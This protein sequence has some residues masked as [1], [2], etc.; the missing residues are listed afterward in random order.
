MPRKQKT[1][2]GHDAQKVE[3]V[4]GQRYGE[5]VEQQQMQTAMPAPKAAADVAPQV[6]GNETVIAAPQKQGPTPEMLQQF[7]AS[8]NPQLLSGT[9]IPDEPITAG[10]PSGPGPGP[11][12][13]S[14]GVNTTPIARTLRRLS[15]TTGNPKWAR[16]ADKANL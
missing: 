8:N 14:L 11:E 2:S 5:G 15:A 3:S 6:R 9:Q 10:L 12:A 13:L 4:A 16:L 1:I 7:L